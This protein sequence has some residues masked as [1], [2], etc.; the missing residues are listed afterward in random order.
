MHRNGWYTVA[1]GGI[2][3]LIGLV[4][5]F[6]MIPFSTAQ[7]AAVKTGPQSH[8]YKGTPNTYRIP[9]AP[10]RTGP[11]PGPAPQHMTPLSP[12]QAA[13]AIQHPFTPSMHEMVIP[14]TRQVRKVPGAL[15]VPVSVAADGLSSDGVLEITVP[16]G[17]VSSTDLA[18][19]A[20]PISLVVDEVAPPSGST[21]GGTGSGDIS[22]GTWTFQLQDA[23]GAELAH[24]LTAPI[25]VHYH[26]KSAHAPVPFGIQPVIFTVNGTLPR[27]L[28]HPLHHM[29][30]AAHQVASYSATTQT[31]TVPMP[32]SAGS[33]S[34]SFS[35]TAP[36]SYFSKPDAFQNDLHTGSLNDTIPIDVPT[37]P[38]G[39]TP[40]L[41]LAYSSE[42]VAQTH[43]P[44]AA[45][46][47]VGE[48]WSLD[49]GEISWSEED[50]PTSGG[51]TNWIDKW[52]I[53]DSFG[54]SGELV[55]P[56][57][58]I[59]TYYDDTV[60]PPFGTVAP[61]YVL[62][63]TATETHTKIVSYTNP[64]ANSYF[65]SS[66]Y[67]VQPPCFRVWLP[68]GIME[69]FGCTPDSLQ[70]YPASPSGTTNYVNAWK[71]DLITDPSGNQIH[72]HYTQEFA[73][74]N[75]I[76]YPRDVVLNSI[77]WDSPACHN[78]QASCTGAAWAPLMRVVPSANDAVAHV[79]SAVCTQSGTLRCDDPQAGPTEGT[80]LITPVTALNDLYVEVRTTGS[81]SWN[82]LHQY[83]FR[84]DQTAANPNGID[85]GN[86]SSQSQA[87]ML[88][89]RQ[90]QEYGT[91]GSGGAGYPPKTFTY[92]YS[93]PGNSAYTE[94][95]EDSQYASYSTTHCGPAWNTGY[96]S[97]GGTCLLWFETYNSAYMTGADNG[98]G[99]HE[100]FAWASARTNQHGVYA[101]AAAPNNDPSYPFACT[102]VQATQSA[103]W[104]TYP[105]NM[106]DDNGWSHMTLIG[107]TAVVED[108]L[109]DKLANPITSSWT[110]N[111]NLEHLSAQE[112]GDCQYGM[113]WGN[114][115]DGDYQDFYNGTFTGF[116][117]AKALNPD[118]S[119]DETYSY[120]T[121]GWGVW[122]PTLVSCHDGQT[123]CPESAGWDVI[124]AAS[125]HPYEQVWYGIPQS[126]VYPLLKEAQTTYTAVCPTST[127]A[128]TPAPTSGPYTGYT[129]HSHLVSEAD[130]DNPRVL[131]DIQTA[132][133]T[134]YQAEGQSNPSSTNSPQSI[135]TNSYD[136]TNPYGH[137]YSSTTTGNDLGATPTTVQQMEYLWHDAI[138][139]ASTSA[140]GTYIVDR[141]EGDYTKDGSGNVQS[142]AFMAYDG[143]A[144]STGSTSGLV[145]GLETASES[146][147]D[148]VHYTGVAK[149]TTAYNTNGDPISTIDAD[150]NGGISGHTATTG[151]CSGS[152][153][154]T[155]YDSVYGTLPSAS[156]DVFN[157]TASTNYTTSQS[158]GYGTWPSSTTD[159]NGQTTSFTYDGLGRITSTTLPGETSGETTTATSYSYANCPATGANQPCAEVDATQRLNSTTTVTTQSFY[160]GYGHLAE[161][162]APG[163]NSQDV[164]QYAQ[165]D[166][167]GQQTFLSQ[168]YFI[169]SSTPAGYVVPDHSQPGTQT[170]YDGLG[171]VITSVAPNSATTQTSYAVTCGVGGTSDTNC[172]E[173][174][175]TV[176][177]L[178]HKAVSYADAL[179]RTRYG[180]RFTGN[181][182]YT[183]Y[184]TVSQ[185]YDYLGDVTSTTY[186]DGSQG[187]PLRMTI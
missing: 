60:N 117:F 81:G 153:T 9:P 54:T 118:T 5:L 114:A 172:Y 150:A 39:L 14:L 97:T 87:G 173:T 112:C 90:V 63:R 125:G 48:G 52:N 170:G 149:T 68:N 122:D 12:A 23:H 47:W 166:P 24:G 157:Q 2:S 79:Y 28:P 142:C 65:P 85:T 53:S 145:K 151:A 181:N 110:Y 137:L 34:G 30:A 130:Q 183:L 64:A 141:A 146:E 73:T 115:N 101:S 13:A 19:A 131:C 61:G 121:E 182:P 126:G 42:S 139:L 167:M 161:T 136:T 66:S 16:A 154:C 160:D 25:T 67:A 108:P 70:W 46:G 26:W 32:M 123:T 78:A 82:V 132:S 45:A 100:T 116:Y 4:I 51:A 80:P 33:G 59:A 95:Y 10:N 187:P 176:D 75:G 94:Y 56:N 129:W 3:F 111:Y 21:D 138:T 98:Q 133:A 180:Q 99:L 124:N 35:T 140:T 6:G 1:R 106:P 72:F 92:S 88:L 107:R 104:N 186:A 20:N 40:D 55:P 175:I 71:V 144:F 58:T 18:S 31:F 134:S 178:Y 156:I 8:P 143:L 37:G 135:V 102:N 15:P 91:G 38:G 27:I 89:L 93:V 50:I 86:G 74:A 169:P 165:Y 83:Q 109:S 49:P 159:P 162:R 69:E 76:T 171:R 184:S 96:Q 185:Q 77:E 119:L 57:T 43:G 62:W 158:F 17:A 36:V 103:G 11:T 152:T 84:Y 41:N 29:G 177:P 155:T 148:C 128:A 22:F 168:P 164:I 120:S 174:T 105:C 113:Y 163:P 147:A 179:G 44:Q 127:I 7:A